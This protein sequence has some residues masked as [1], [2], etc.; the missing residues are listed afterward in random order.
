MI[1]G[2]I[3]L[4]VV[5]AVNLPFALAARWWEQRYDLARGPWIDWLLEPWASSVERSSS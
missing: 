3:T 1:V 5:W 4:V 2:M